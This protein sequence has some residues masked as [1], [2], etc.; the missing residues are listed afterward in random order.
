MRY[1]DP[2][3]YDDNTNSQYFILLENLHSRLFSSIKLLVVI[4]LSAYLR[5]N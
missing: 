1:E 3:F 5:V 4:T 2:F